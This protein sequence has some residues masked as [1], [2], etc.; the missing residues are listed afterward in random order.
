[1][2]SALRFTVCFTEAGKLGLKVIDLFSAA[3]NCFHVE[4]LNQGVIEDGS[5]LRRT[6]RK[7]VVVRVPHPAFDIQLALFAKPFEV[8]RLL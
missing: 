1:M 2:R 3:L 5:S 8:L 7:R 6:K 4:P